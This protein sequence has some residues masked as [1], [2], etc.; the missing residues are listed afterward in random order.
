M[1]DLTL[2]WRSVATQWDI[3]YKWLQGLCIDIEQCKENCPH[4][5]MQN[6]AHK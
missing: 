3:N 6:L 5:Y 2:A 1:L 4:L